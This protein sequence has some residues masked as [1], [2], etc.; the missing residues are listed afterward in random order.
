MFINNKSTGRSYNYVNHEAISLA[1]IL[2]YS[3]EIAY[4]DMQN[5]QMRCKMYA[6]DMQ[7]PQC[8]V[9]KNVLLHYAFML[10]VL[11]EFV[12]CNKIYVNVT[13]FLHSGFSHK[14]ITIT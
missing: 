1:S 9:R 4:I 11:G 10:Q 14:I 6:N 12:N 3:I 2:R 13:L 8:I 7:K 5:M